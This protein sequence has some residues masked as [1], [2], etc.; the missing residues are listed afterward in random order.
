TT[1]P[2]WSGLNERPAARDDAL[3]AAPGANFCISESLARC[4][5]SGIP[6]EHRPGRTRHGKPAHQAAPYPIRMGS[7]RRRMFSA[8]RKDEIAAT[9]FARRQFA[10]VFAGA[11][12]WRLLLSNR[13]L[14][15]GAGGRMRNG[16]ARSQHW[17]AAHQ[18]QA[19]REGSDGKF[20]NHLNAAHQISNGPMEMLMQPALNSR[21]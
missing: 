11:V 10:A 8:Q 17:R 1:M 18:R 16:Q 5:G 2:S 14:E 7:R 21:R 6:L 9:A 13:S 12:A 20:H 19:G 4:Q 3:K 15:A